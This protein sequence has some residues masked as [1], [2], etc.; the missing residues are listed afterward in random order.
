MNCVTLDSFGCKVVSKGT[1]KSIRIGDF[2]RIC[3]SKKD[4][5]T[6]ILPINCVHYISKSDDILV[7]LLFP[8]TI[9]PMVEY[10]VSENDVVNDM[11]DNP[12]TYRDKCLDIRGISECDNINGTDCSRC[13]KCPSYTT[14]EGCDPGETLTFSNIPTPYL[15]FTLLI[16]RRMNQYFVLRTVVHA[17]KGELVSDNTP[18]YRCIFGNVH[19]GGAICWGHDNAFE[20]ENSLLALGAMFSAFFSSPFND[21][22]D[23]SSELE[24]DHSKWPRFSTL[25]LLRYLENKPRYEDHLFVSAAYDTYKTLI[26]KEAL[27]LTI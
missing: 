26:K 2:V 3:A 1:T 25:N 8:P 13:S 21:D 5:A 9:V 16:S 11:I 4:I 24:D 6:P 12:L 14:L 15:L 18:L 23:D 10:L 17:L 22:L 27:Q 7:S 19:S 20:G